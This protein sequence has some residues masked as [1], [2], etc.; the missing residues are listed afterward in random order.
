MVP[1]WAT[2]KPKSIFIVMLLVFTGANGIRV[3]GT[4]YLAKEKMVEMEKKS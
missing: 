4:K 2:A 3:T 1:K